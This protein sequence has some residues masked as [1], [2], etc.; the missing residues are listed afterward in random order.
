MLK[1]HQNVRHK[2]KELHIC[3]YGAIEAGIDYILPFVCQF[4][5]Y[6]SQSHL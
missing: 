2:I 1:Y 5:F 3:L 4:V 6:L